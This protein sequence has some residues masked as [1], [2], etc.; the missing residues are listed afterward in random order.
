MSILIEIKNANQLGE[1]KAEVIAM[2]FTR[3]PEQ[4]TAWKAFLK[5]VLGRRRQGERRLLSIAS[6]GQ[7]GGEV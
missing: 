4:L 5:S 1:Q 7:I 6:L 3:N 2:F